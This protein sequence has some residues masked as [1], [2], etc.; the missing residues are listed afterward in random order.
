MKAGALTEKVTAALLL[1][2]RSYK[3][4]AKETLSPD[5][6]PLGSTPFLKFCA[7]CII[8]CRHSSLIMQRGG[9]LLTT[10]PSETIF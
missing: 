8:R 3:D 7:I 10:M 4:A 9:S 6:T 2:F 1:F 5:E